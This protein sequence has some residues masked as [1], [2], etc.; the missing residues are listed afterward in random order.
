MLTRLIKAIIVAAVLAMV[1]ESLPDIKRYLELR[2][3]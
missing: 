3:M 1:I 2:E